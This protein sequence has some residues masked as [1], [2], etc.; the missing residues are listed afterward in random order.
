[1]VPVEGRE[2]SESSSI[3]RVVTLEKDVVRN[4]DLAP[5]PLVGCIRRNLETQKIGPTPYDLQR[6]ALLGSFADFHV[7]ATPVGPIGTWLYDNTVVRVYGGEVRWWWQDDLA[8]EWAL[9][10]VYSGY[11]L[12]SYGYI[13]QLVG[14]RMLYHCHDL[15]YNEDE[16]KE[17]AAYI[18]E[19]AIADPPGRIAKNRDRAY[20][21]C[22][23]CPVKIEC[24]TLDAVTPQGK[25]DWGRSYPFP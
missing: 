10:Q 13:I 7:I 17:I 6:N 24:D 2:A 22:K 12:R 4:L 19:D 16:Q 3:D 25:A 23:R 8:D 11:T 9:V 21:T 18:I 1:M 15:P 20:L 5:N 14:P